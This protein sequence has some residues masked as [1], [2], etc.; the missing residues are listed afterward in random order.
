MYLLR[1]AVWILT[2]VYDYI[3]K[4]IAFLTSNGNSSH[5]DITMGII[6][7]VITLVTSTHM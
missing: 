7:H 5:R 2:S 3:Y 1:E 6:C 4:S